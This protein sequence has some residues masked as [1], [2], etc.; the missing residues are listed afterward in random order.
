MPGPGPKLAAPAS[1]WKRLAQRKRPRER[2]RAKS[3]I[4]SGLH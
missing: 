2:A 3:S 4:S 1:G